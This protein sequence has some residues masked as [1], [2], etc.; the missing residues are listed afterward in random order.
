MSRLFWIVAVAQIQVLILENKLQELTLFPNPASQTLNILN[1]TF[2]KYEIHSLTGSII[3]SGKNNSVI[4][5]SNLE[6]GFYLISFTKIS[7]KTIPYI[8]PVPSAVFLHSPLYLACVLKSSVRICTSF[9]LS[10]PKATA[11]N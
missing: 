5:V 10:D 8:N 7:G 11:S 2:E 3:Q 4:D 9:S 1:G 6:S